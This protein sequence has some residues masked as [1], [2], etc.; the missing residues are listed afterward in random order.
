GYR[1]VFTGEGEDMIETFGYMAEALLLAVI[2]VYLIL[3]A[4]FESFIEPFSIMLSLP[5]SIVGMAG[6]LLLTGD[7]VNI[8]SLIGLIMLMGLVTKNAILLVDYAKVLQTRGMERSEAV[9]TAGRTRLRPILMTTL[10]MIFGMLPLALGIGA[11]AEMRAPMARAVVG[12]LITSTFLTLLVVPVV[13]TLLDDFATWMRRRWDGKKAAV[14]AVVGLLV[15]LLGMPSLGPPAAAAADSAAVENLTL[16]EALRA[17]VA[18]NRDVAKATEL[19]IFLEGKYV[20]ERA[21]ALPQFLAT[22]E[23][24]RA[25]DESQS[26]FGAPPGSNRYAAQVG[27]SQPLYSSG[28]VSAGIRAASQGLATADDR[29]RIA[30]H[31]VLREVH[32]VFHD[33]LLAREL[34]RIAVEDRAQKGRHLDEARKKYEAGTATDYDVLAAEVA[35]QNAGPE[36]VRTGNLV[37]VSRERLRFL[38]GRD[39]REVDAKGDLSAVVGDPPNYDNALGTAVDHRPELSDLRHR[40]GVAQ[41]LLVIA[42]AGNLPRLDFRGALGWQEIDFGV[43]DVNGKTWSAGV[44]ASW[45][46]FDGLRTRGRVAQ[47]GSD[48]RTLRI[49]EAQLLDAIA[50]E[51]RDAVNAV[52]EAGEIVNALSGTVDQAD[53]L[54][55]LA[56]KGYEYGVKTRLEV[57][58]AQ[59]NR[60]RALGNLARARRDY[61]VAGAALR[62]AMGTLGDGLAPPTGGKPAFRPGK[63]PVAL[64]G[65]VLKGEPSLPK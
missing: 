49:E 21:S 31:A 36:I 55:A 22:A 61:L 52:R 26:I 3:A 58:D 35:Q 41:E 50:L 30:R 42:R 29:L 27:V 64:V 60:S 2:F 39:G 16:D 5:L 43:V 11:G 10:A 13:Y 51:V 24:L 54:V 23:A 62:H 48:V 59:L 6:M 47:A 9:I 7:T 38:L 4:Q 53:R 18:N 1:V 28:V 56:E 45:P 40:R 37:R 65:E 12:G 33:I 25:W 14:G 57:D 15:L 34:N 63:S 20:E 32:A 44:F 17:A 19:R 46:L 8:M